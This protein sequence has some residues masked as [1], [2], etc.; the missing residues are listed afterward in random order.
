MK[1]K[2]VFGTSVLVFML[3]SMAVISVVA[4]PREPGVD[5][6]DWFM[7]GDITGSWSSD[8]PNAI[9]P[10]YA[11]NET[12]WA[13]LTITSVVDTNVTSQMEVR[14]KNG[15]S[16]FIDGWIDVDT[17]DNDKLGL[18]LIA[19]NL[20][21]GSPLYTSGSYSTWIINETITRSYPPLDGDRSTNHL[22]LTMEYSLLPLLYV[23]YSENRYWDRSSGIQVEWS[24]ESIIEVE[25]NQTSWSF[26]V[27]ITDTTVWVIPEFPTWASILLILI[28]LTV[29]TAIYKRRLRKTPPH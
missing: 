1:K 19:R 23:Y 21:A 13:D 20:D 29:T 25:G 28:I 3:F 6:G 22:N 5:A 15:T 10:D 12:E 16:E 17:G 2:T 26:S 18:W 24:Q 14:Y 27:R 8:D 4:Q 7:Y 9:I 11:T